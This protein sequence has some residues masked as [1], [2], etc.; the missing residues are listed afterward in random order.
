MIFSRSNIIWSKHQHKVCY[1]EACTAETAVPSF[2]RWL[3]SHITFDQR[4]HPSHIARPGCYPLIID[5]IVHKKCLTKVLMDRGNGLNILYVDTLDAMRIPRSKLR[6]AGSPFHGVILG[7][8][9]Y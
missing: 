2:L 5:P 8:Q 4:D 3:K 6:L 7:A 1:R 9:A